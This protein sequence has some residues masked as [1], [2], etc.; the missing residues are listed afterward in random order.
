MW[1]PFYELTWNIF[2][3]CCLVFYIFPKGIILCHK[4]KTI[5][6]CPS[7]PAG[8][9]LTL[10]EQLLPLLIPTTFFVLMECHFRGHC[11]SWMAAR[12]CGDP[13]KARHQHATFG[14]V[15]VEVSL[16]MKKK[17]GL[18][19][20]IY[21]FFTHC[22]VFFLWRQGYLKKRKIN[23]PVKERW[24]WKDPEMTPG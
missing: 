16:Y 14:L 20:I 24:A 1:I 11:L 7:W 19:E 17:C 21:L 22:L 10:V 6:S 13:L 3:F 18:F 2:Y 9:L 15:D 4:T 12:V 5:R 23:K 8:I